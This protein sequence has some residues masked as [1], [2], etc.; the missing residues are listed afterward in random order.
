MLNDIRYAIRVLIKNPGFSLVAILSLALGIG[1]NTAIFSM[2]NSLLFAPLPVAR[3]A[4]LV[5]I[6]TT[7]VKN[8]GPLPVSHYNFIDYRD[9]NS[10]FSGVTAYNFAQVNLNKGPGNSQQLFGNVVAGNYF[11]VLG[12]KFMLGRGFVPD[13][14]RAEGANPVVVLSYGCWQREFGGNSSARWSV[15]RFRSTAGSSR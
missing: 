4:E 6:F 2:I 1:A 5:S 11:D 12:V 10:V 3:P 7:D 15:S 9:K 13:E 8:P 14:D